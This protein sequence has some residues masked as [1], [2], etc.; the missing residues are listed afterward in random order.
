MMVASRKDTNEESK[1]MS[2]VVTGV[3]SEANTVR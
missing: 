3:I 2:V 1:F